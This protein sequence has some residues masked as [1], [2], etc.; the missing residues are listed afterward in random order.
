VVYLIINS[1]P[2]RLLQRFPNA[3][4]VVEPRPMTQPAPSR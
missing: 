3:R 2:R 1:L 4:N